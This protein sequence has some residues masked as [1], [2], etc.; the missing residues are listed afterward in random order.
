[1]A[2]F[3]HSAI[4]AFLQKVMSTPL[5]AE[6]IHRHKHLKNLAVIEKIVLTTS[7]PLTGSNEN[8]WI[9]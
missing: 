3:P 8:L 7:R 1:M 5:E 2:T 6:F 4:I 9:N